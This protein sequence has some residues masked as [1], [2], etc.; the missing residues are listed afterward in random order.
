MTKLSQLAIVAVFILSVVV[1]VLFIDRIPPAV[2]IDEYNLALPAA[3]ISLGHSTLP[4]FG[5]GWY[6][7]PAIFFYYL[8]LLFNIFGISITTIKIAWLIPAIISFLDGVMVR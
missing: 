7:T 3:Q 8:A 6:A 4:W 5:F 2:F 1:R